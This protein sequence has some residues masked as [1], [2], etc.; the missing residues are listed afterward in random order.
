M[1]LSIKKRARSPRKIEPLSLKNLVVRIPRILQIINAR[2]FFDCEHFRFSNRIYG[3]PWSLLYCFGQV[4]GI[5][6]HAA[7]IRLFNKL[8]HSYKMILTPTYE[9][10]Q[11]IRIKKNSGNIHVMEIYKETAK[12]K[13]QLNVISRLRTK[14]FMDEARYREQTKEISN[15]IASLNKTVK[16]MSTIED[17]DQTLNEL[18]CLISTFRERDSDMVEFEPETFDSIRRMASG[19]VGM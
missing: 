19:I 8:L 18:D 7:F 17:E 10:L 3:T 12:L 5:C 15:K 9:M 14:G 11:E 4:E 2:S 6:K 1:C 13:E 16:K